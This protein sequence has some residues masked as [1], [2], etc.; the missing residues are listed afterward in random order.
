MKVISLGWGVQSFT[1]A[2]M[3]A[4]GELEPVDY[5]IHA[6][7]T[8]ESVLT[9][10]FAEKWTP[11]MEERGVKVVTVRVES[12]DFHKQEK[13]KGL[14]TPPL[15]T[16]TDDENGMLNRSCTQR[17]KIAPMRKWLQSNRG[18][19]QVEQWMGISLDEFQR[20][21]PSNVKYIKH[22]WPLIEK[23]MSRHD[24]KVWLDKHNI[25]IPPRSSCVFCPF[26]SRKEWRNV[27][28]IPQDWKKAVEVDEQIR[29]ARPPYDLYVCNQRKPLPECDFDSPQD[30]GQLELWNEECSGYC[31][32]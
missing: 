30:K 7:T 18:G 11:W 2:A 26:H 8:H 12:A 9:Y 22:R 10:A 19:E 23:R 21:K 27:K 5:A 6:D 4:L 20:M 32:L 28:Q 25:E 31:G 17:W 1:L 3:V 15:F 29:K 13:L 16:K 14:G 24:C